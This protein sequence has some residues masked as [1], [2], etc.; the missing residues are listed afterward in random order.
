MPKKLKGLMP[1][2]KEKK[3][4]LR[5]KIHSKSVL[6]QKNPMNEIIQELKSLLGIFD[7]A[8]AGLV[9]VKTDYKNSE[10]II[11]TSAKSLDRVRSALLFIRRIGTDEVILQNIKT[12]GTIKAVGR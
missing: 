4:Y 10:V 9:P 6:K 1:S 12:S 5:I 2:L 3:R 11:R 8:S 7:S